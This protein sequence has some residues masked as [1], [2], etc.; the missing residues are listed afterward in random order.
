MDLKKRF[1]DLLKTIG[2]KKYNT[3]AWFWLRIGNH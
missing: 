2:F 3:G 1:T